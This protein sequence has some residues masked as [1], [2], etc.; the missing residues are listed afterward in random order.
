M[1]VLTEQQY[2]D[3]LWHYGTK[4]HSGRYPWGSGEEPYQH[5]SW[6]HADVKRLRD[7]GMNEKEIAQMYGI[8][9][10]DLRSKISL[11]RSQERAAKTAEAE[12]LRSQGLNISEIGRQM[13]INE[14]SVRSLLSAGTRERTAQSQATIE[15][16][17][18]ALQS[19]EYLDIGKGVA[20]SMGIT[21][22]RLDAAVEAMKDKGYVVLNV[23]V[24]Q[25]GAPGQYTTIKVLAPEGSTTGDVWKN[26]EKIGLVG[27]HFDDQ[28]STHASKNFDPDKI[29]SVDPKRLMVN[30]GKG[31]G[32]GEEKD[33][34]IE[35][36]RGVQDLD[37]GDA[38]YAQVR[39]QVGDGHYAKGMAIYADDLPDGVD[40]RFNTNKGKDTPVLGP[41]DNSILKPL[42]DSDDNPFGATI[43]RQRG[44][45]NIVNEEGTWGTWSK[46]IASQ[47][48]S[49]QDPS[50]A[51]KQLDLTAADKFAEFEE[52]N[53]LTNPTLRKHLL[54][55]FADSCDSDAVALKAAGFPRQGSYV[56]LPVNSI[57]PNEIYAPNYK[58]GERVALIRYPHG[59]TFEIPELVVNNKNPEARRLFENAK[60]AVGIHH[61]VAERLSG[62][63]FDGDTV[64]VI[65]NNRRQIK[66]SSPLTGL[67]NFDPKTAYPAYPGMPRIKPQTK[68]TEMGKVS[69][70]ITDM[71]IHGADTDE[72][73]RAVRHSMVVI[74]SEKHNLN[75]K[76][77]YIDN[78]IAELKKKYQGGEK[79]GA[80][81]L[82]S[83]AK[84]E[85][86]VPQRKAGRYAID[87]NTGEKIYF[88]TG[89]SYEKIRKVVD[90][91]TGKVSYENTGKVIG[92]T[93]RSTKMAEAKDAFELS[94]GTDIEKVYATYANQM[95]ALGNRARKETL[96]IKEPPASSSARRG[97][98][99]E[100]ASLKSK[101]QESKANAPR[102]RN[103][104]LFA[105]VRSKSLIRDNPDM[106]DDGKKRVRSQSLA[107][108]RARSGAYRSVIDIT[109]SEWNAIQA[110]AVSKTTLSEILRRA[111][112]DQV[113]KYATPKQ[114]VSMTP[115]KIARAKA[116]LAIGYTQAEVAEALGVSTSTIAKNII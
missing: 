27:V 10:R 62:A 108:G 96:S 65:P 114:T 86:R 83:K 89:S 54:T 3:E 19:N 87:P 11:S 77:S 9:V 91:A 46:T 16:L 112:P 76:Q 39:I 60:D 79:A 57:K 38:R 72:L 74:D 7:N 18:K 37:L 106:D 63:D 26:R 58:D 53:S 28:F 23:H 94:S 2:V 59:G 42:K 90:K 31:D 69:N 50:V 98:A 111:D 97:Y 92:R 55:E 67:Q 52:I 71:T 116:M 30:Y 29:V 49:K 66:S 51:K 1:P 95:K 115:A 40:I 34:I 5:E 17:G 61:T 8:T 101:L 70:L 81:T 15:A 36:R 24:E 105:D 104:Q 113:R 107:I 6:F 82:I 41:K 110:G 35:I 68:Q 99:K 45:L 109:P 88:E 43:S 48:L 14:S 33:G 12:R 85:V 25:A 44:A 73:A 100:I 103:A 80:S 64:V 75:Y 84:G 93:T 47:V 20:E 4:R 102:E 22:Q 32:T 78:G 21:Q 13:G 56:I